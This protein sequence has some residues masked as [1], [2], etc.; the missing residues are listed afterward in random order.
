MDHE[1]PFIPG[2]TLSRLLYDEIVAPL[3]A[4]S[5]PGIPYAASLIGHGSD[6][7]GFDTARSMDHDW[8]PRLNLLLTDE[9]CQRSRQ[10][11]LNELDTALPVAFHGIPIDLEPSVDLPGDT[12]EF[13]NVAGSGRTHGIRIDT[14]TS[15]LQANLG[16][17]T[18]DQFNIPAWLTTPQ[19]SLLELISGPLFRDDIGDFSRVRSV[20]G[21]YPDDLW[22][23]L[24]AARWKRIAQ[25]E[26]FIGRCGEL[27]DDTGSHIVTLSL[28]TD[29]IH[30]AFLQS[31]RYA[32]YAKWLGTAFTRLPLAPELRPHLDQA[33]YAR[34]WREREAGIVHA[35]VLLAH[36]HNQLGITDFIDPASQ[37]FHDRPFRVIF[38][39][40]FSR[41][42][43]G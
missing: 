28:V 24:M 33:R 14:L 16:I 19:Q 3:M 40:R 1:A 23:Y 11:I 12:P 25:L 21:W 15:V 27:D 29:V 4:R 32:P 36:R 34:S 13:H 9:D 31:R 18:I 35:A 26:A 20:L 42:L 10:A 8:G 39:E 2:H 38:A 22:R 30:L 17:A 37:R 6:V 7:L 5:F 43:R 41:A